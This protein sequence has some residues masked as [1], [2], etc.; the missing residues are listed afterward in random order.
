MIHIEKDQNIV[1][2]ENLRVSTSTG[3]YEDG[4]LV[5]FYNIDSP[6][7]VVGTFQ[8]QYIKYGGMVYTF[9]GHKELGEAI[10]KIDPESTHTAASYVRMSN[11]LLAQ[12]E[13]GSLEPDSLDQ[14]I[15]EEQTKMED[16]MENPPETPPEDIPAEEVVPEDST[17]TEADTTEEPLPEDSSVPEVDAPE[18]VPEDV[19]ETD[20]IPAPDVIPEDIVPDVA[21][22]EL[23]P[24]DVVPDELVPS[25]DEPVSAI[26]RKRK[27]G[28]V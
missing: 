22:D 25:P 16:K 26:V 7:V 27:R 11:Q 24:V 1:E 20:N 21:P 17:A 28:I 23:V 9:G 4:A 18:V 3:D 8:A 10:L 19:I 5:E 14:V 6:D 13:G 12:M 2:N 15:S